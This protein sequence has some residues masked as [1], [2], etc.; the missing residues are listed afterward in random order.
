MSSINSATISG[1]LV[2]D[3]ELRATQGGSFILSF[4]V[5]VNERSKQEDGSWADEASY[6]KCKLFGKRAQSVQPHLTKGCKVSVQGR[7][8]Q[9]RWQ[10]KDG[11][12]R[13]EV[14][15]RVDEFEF[16]DKRQAQP[17]ANAPQSHQ[18]PLYD[19]EIPF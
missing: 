7:L 9:S 19:E 15:I 10:S 12:N 11:Q 2:R 16:M 1:N 14:Y 5:A 13:S 18:E 4:D 3:S 8:R 17:V 6:I